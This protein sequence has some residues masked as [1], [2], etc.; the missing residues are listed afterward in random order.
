MRVCGSDRSGGTGFGDVKGGEGQYGTVLWVLYSLSIWRFLECYWCVGY[1]NIRYEL[2]CS[3]IA[4]DQ[5]KI[6]LW[7]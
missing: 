2:V 7:I 5:I 6:C 3:V 4:S 1:T